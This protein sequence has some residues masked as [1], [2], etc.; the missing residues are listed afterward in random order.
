[1]SAKDLY[2]LGGVSSESSSREELLLSDAE[3]DEFDTLCVA[4]DPLGDALEL[5]LV[6]SFGE[7]STVIFCCSCSLLQS[8]LTFSL[9]ITSLLTK[10]FSLTGLYS[11]YAFD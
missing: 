4:V 2:F 3:D 7:T 8:Q 9:N 1:M 11:L 6:S 10:I 5:T